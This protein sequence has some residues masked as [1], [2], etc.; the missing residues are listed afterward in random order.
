MT[1]RQIGKAFVLAAALVF[2]TTSAFGQVSG[3]WVFSSSL[4]IGSEI[5]VDVSKIE[6]QQSGD[7][8]TG[9][10]NGALG[11]SKPVKGS[12]QN[13]QVTLSVDGK[14]PT[15][16]M[17]MIATLTGSLTEITGS[18][19]L[20]AGPSQGTWTSRRPGAQ[21]D[22][23]PSATVTADYTSQR[24]GR[25]HK[26]VPA[27][28]PK[29]GLT[30]TLAS[31]AKVIPRP[32]DAWPQAPR[33]FKVDL[34][35]EGFDYPRKIEA[36][37]NGDVFLAESNLGEIKVMRGMNKDGKAQSV[38]TFATGLTRPFGIAFYPAGPNPRYMYVANTGSVVR[39]P[40]RRGDLA[41]TGEPEIIIPDLPFGG[42]LVGGGH[43][44]RD[45]AFSNDNGSLFVS[46]GSWSEND[47]TD[48]NPNEERRANILEYTPEGQFIRTY[49]TGVRNP[50]GIAIN[51]RDGQLWTSINERDMQGNDLV[52]DY[53]TH[54]EPF[55][56]YG[57]PWFYVGSNYDPEHVGK[58][59]E[60]I[61]KILLPD[62]LIQAH[63]A[64]LAVAFYEGAQFPKRYRGDLF[65]ALH[66]SW[67][68]GVRTGYEVIRVPVKR[69]LANGEYEDFLTGFVT[70]EG[71]VWG[72][73]VG[74]TTA[75]DGSLLV[76]DDAGKCVWRVAYT[77][78]KGRD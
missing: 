57:W 27:D 47:D 66:G 34:Y 68:R 67:N 42:Q 52:P 59:P 58:H 11:L 53:I 78:P 3:T 63:S 48:N 39:F 38:S 65:S 54:L 15:N 51:R 77:Q 37:P 46:V 12:F 17:P 61:N 4:P 43:W 70:P 23:E 55:G 64:P 32:A 44:T 29:A 10:Y 36:A 50:V 20:T 30:L 1:R 2:Y 26:I 49:A 22:L 14:F 28:L 72:R 13:G 31:A 8:I 5:L 41:A 62:V 6:L 75:R 45:I 18:G 74:V 19:S 35:A 69:G 33:G 25:T 21:E 9:T 73:P 16:A 40:Y 56:F 24:P 71:K 76:S 7:T 60:L